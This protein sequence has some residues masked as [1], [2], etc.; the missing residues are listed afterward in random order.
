MPHNVS[1]TRRLPKLLLIAGLSNAGKSSFADLLQ[2]TS[3]ITHVPLDKYFLSVPPGEKFLDWAQSP[4]SIDWGLLDRHLEILSGG[5]ECYSPAYDPWSTGQR[6]SEGG[7]ECHPR[8]RLM[9]PSDLGYAVTGCFAFECDPEGFS[10]TRV[11]VETPL[12]TI[13]S[14]HAGREV[15]ADEVD[16]ILNSR[17]TR[18]YKTLLSYREDADVVVRGDASAN[19]GL[20]YCHSLAG[21]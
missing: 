20:R 9:E 6:L 13:A 17:H 2:K 7:D 21:S 8:S 4:S 1:V 12:R 5:H 3:S 14:R 15:L 16:Q 11:F 18:S 10:V 19:E